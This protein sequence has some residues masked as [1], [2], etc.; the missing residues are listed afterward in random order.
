MARY[1]DVAGQIIVL[2]L[3]ILK[4]LIVKQ[5]GKLKIDCIGPKD[6]A[7]SLVQDKGF[8][9]STC[10]MDTKLLLHCSCLL[11]LVGS[12]S[13]YIVTSLL[14]RQC[15]AGI[16]NQVP[17][18]QSTNQDETLLIHELTDSNQIRQTIQA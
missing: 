10:D 5:L 16:S 18:S 17:Y 6:I 12:Y 11:T 4:C 8:L 1:H 2:L 15:I 14:A 7:L 13:A 3:G 9:D